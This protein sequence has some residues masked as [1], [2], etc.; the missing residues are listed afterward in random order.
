MSIRPKNGPTPHEHISQGSHVV[1]D[2]AQP[3]FIYLPTHVGG[4]CLLI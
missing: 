4:N 1:M 2:K 3:T